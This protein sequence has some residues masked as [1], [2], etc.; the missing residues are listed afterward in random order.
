MRRLLTFIGMALWATAVQAQGVALSGVMGQRALLVIDGQTQMLAVGATA[1]GVKLL[2]LRGEEARIEREG[3]TTLLRVGA[4]PVSMGAGA[5]S[6]GGSEIVMTAGP[7]G[8]FISQ[9]SINGRAVRFMVDTGATMI[10]MGQA[11]AERLGIDWKAGERGLASTANGV[12]P[13][14]RVNLAS[15]RIGDVEVN[16]VDA[17]VSAMA[18]PY[19]LLGNSFLSRF[20]M[21]RDSDVM[22]LELRR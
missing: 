11:E 21:R 5:R 9:G 17:S 8:H 1:R 13:T 4:A 19:L 7:G 16:N 22:R 2:E 12:I 18:M 6:G 10:A 3:K 14:Y 20:S 15:V